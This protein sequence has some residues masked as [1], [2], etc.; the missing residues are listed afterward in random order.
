MT[1]RNFSEDLYQ[2]FLKTDLT[3]LP[4]R[5]NDYFCLMD[6]LKLFDYPGRS[7]LKTPEALAVCESI[8]QA[9]REGW[10]SDLLNHRDDIQWFWIPP[11]GS[12]DNAIS[13]IDLVK[14]YQTKNS[15]NSKIKIEE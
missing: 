8:Q 1:T 7:K 6:S 13:L 10:T 5:S 12:C 15:A 4:L 9:I 11:S 3:N 14:H 2:R